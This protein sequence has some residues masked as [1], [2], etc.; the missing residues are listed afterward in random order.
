MER[1]GTKS[2]PWKAK[3][4][5]RRRAKSRPLVSTIK[6][7]SAAEAEN[8]TRSDPIRWTSGAVPTAAGDLELFSPRNS[9]PPGHPSPNRRHRHNPFA[10]LPAD[11][12]A[13]VGKG[14]EALTKR[15]Q[16]AAAAEDG[17]RP[18][19]GRCR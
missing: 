3:G 14:G 2:L 9:E 6:P 15:H 10:S 1:P 7:E 12:H 13:N 18:V 16:Q 5:P 11:E 17:T 19:S 4:K 8:A